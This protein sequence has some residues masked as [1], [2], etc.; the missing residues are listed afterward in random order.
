M[1]SGDAPEGFFQMVSLYSVVDL[2]PRQK[3][4]PSWPHHRLI[5][6]LVESDSTV[7]LAPFHHSSDRSFCNHARLHTQVPQA[8]ILKTLP[9]S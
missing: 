9:D 7:V 8:S 5:H 2:D 3:P 6:D 4:L 1:E